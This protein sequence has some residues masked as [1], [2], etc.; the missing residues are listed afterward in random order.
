MFESVPGLLPWLEHSALM[1][2]TSDLTAIPPGL[3]EWFEEGAVILLD[4]LAAADPVESVWSWSANKRVA[5][6]L[7]MMPIETA[8][9]R[10]DAQLAHGRTRQ[11]LDTLLLRHSRLA[12]K[13]RPMQSPTFEACTANIRI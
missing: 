7:R 2:G 1:G 5:H 3:I 10:W 8:V 6:Y 4:T 12:S 9:H 11:P 13:Q